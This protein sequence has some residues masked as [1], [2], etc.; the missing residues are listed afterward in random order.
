[1]F[2]EQMV[3][4]AVTAPVLAAVKRRK[5][6]TANE[7]VMQRRLKPASTEV[8]SS[9]YLNLVA[10]EMALSSWLQGW[11]NPTVR[12]S[13]FVNRWLSATWVT[14]A[15]WPEEDREDEGAT[16]ATARQGDEGIAEPMRPAGRRAKM[17]DPAATVAM[18]EMARAERVAVTVAALS[19]ESINWTPIY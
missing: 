12:N 3:A 10:P 15:C 11:H 5:D 7:V 8:I 13:R 18:A 6:V 4:M 9:Y 2:P 1:M 16:E 14:S 17:V 19:L